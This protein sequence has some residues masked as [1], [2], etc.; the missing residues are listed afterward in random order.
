MMNTKN[1][2]KGIFKAFVMVVLSGFVFLILFIGSL[3]YN[4]LFGKSSKVEI[5]QN[6]ISS[7]IKIVS[8]LI[9]S[10]Q[11]V[12]QDLAYILE[13]HNVNVTEIEIL[14]ES[15]L[16]NNNELFGSAIAFEPYQFDKD[17]LYFASYVYRSGDTN[18]FTSLNDPEYNYF[19]KDWYLVPKTLEKPTWSEPYYDEGGGNSLMST[20][21]VPFYHF[22]GY[23]EKFNGIVT[24][25]VSI[26]WLINTFN[27][28]ESFWKG[29][30][31][32]ISENG[33]IITASNKDWVFNE[34]IFTLAEE[35]NLPVLREAGRE[36]QKGKSGM[37]IIDEFNDQKNWRL[38]YTAIHANNWG[39]VLLISENELYNK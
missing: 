8:R 3:A 39:F 6:H 33:T 27:S 34:T 22:D 29:Y 7:Q 15:V 32:L 11:K 16:L 19:Y 17:S 38:F 21:S 31:M 4:E 24:V 9:E 10:V 28:L 30:L 12:P 35:L 2:K 23:D 1:I 26:E 13:F 20:Y 18:S 25:D 14:L 5:F 36:L 37:K